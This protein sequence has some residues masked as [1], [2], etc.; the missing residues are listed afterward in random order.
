MTRPDGMVRSLLLLTFAK[1]SF[2]GDGADSPF[3]SFPRSN[4]HRVQREHRHLLA[5]IAHRPD[6]LGTEV[7]LFFALPSL[8]RSLCSCTCRYEY[9]VIGCLLVV[10]H[11]FLDHVD[12][13]V[14][15]VHKRLYGENIDDPI[16][17]GFLDAFCDKIVNV[18]SLW[19]IL[20]E[21]NFQET[22]FT[23]SLAFVLLCYTIIG[24][25]TAIGI[26]RLQDYFHAAS[27]KKK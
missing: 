5:N 22:S 23:T 15:K 11:D 10:L 25:E 9:S 4:D 14:A 17:G 7:T 8:H 24:L 16:F 27:E 20:Q 26:V 12:G 13:I 3:Y 6:R 21:T 1:T 19:T 18:F 2:T